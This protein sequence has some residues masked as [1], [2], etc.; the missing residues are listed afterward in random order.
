MELDDASR[1]ALAECRRVREERE[2]AELEARF[3]A[4][5][6]TRVDTV[7][8]DRVQYL[9]PRGRRTLLTADDA[10]M[11]TTANRRRARIRGWGLS[12]RQSRDSPPSDPHPEFPSALG[13][14]S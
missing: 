1:A 9:L 6:R 14:R 8:P 13:D 10:E 7:L 11:A 4:G 5:L 3:A 2:R 12:N